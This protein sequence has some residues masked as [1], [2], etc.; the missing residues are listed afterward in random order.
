MCAIIT[1]RRNPGRV[2]A[3]PSCGDGAFLRHPPGA[4]GIELDLRPLP[5]AR[6]RSTLFAYPE[7]EQFDTIIGNPPYV[8]IQ[9]I[10]EGT[11]R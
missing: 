9:D 7:R 10:A 5:P 4:V 3:R 8:R 2:L 6:R 11:R 1:L